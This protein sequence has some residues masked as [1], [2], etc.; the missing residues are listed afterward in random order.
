MR[1]ETKLYDDDGN[2][3]VKISSD[4]AEIHESELYKIYNYKEYPPEFEDDLDEMILDK[5]MKIKAKRK[6][7]KALKK[8]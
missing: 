2:L 4:S 7:L 1:Y 3:L 6:I 8:K 5:A